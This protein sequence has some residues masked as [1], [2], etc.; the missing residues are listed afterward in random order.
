MT[1]QL[2][3]SDVERIAALDATE[4]AALV[5][6]G[7]LT[8]ADLVS[9]AITRIEQANPA[10]NAV[11]TT[12]FEQAL[13]FVAD[14]APSGP[15]GGVPFLL[16]DLVAE[17]AGMRYAAGSEFLRDH[18]STV[19]SELVVRL[20]RAG[21]V[22][23]G[24]TNTCEFGMVPTTEPLRF[25]ATRNPWDLNRT[26]GGSS[27]GSAAAVASGMVPMAHAN[28]AGGSIRIPASCCGLFGLKPTRGRN[29]LGPLYGDAYGGL[30]VEHA[31]TRSVRDSAALLD[32]T[33]G[34]AP[35]DPCAAVGPVGGLSAGG[36]AAEVSQPPGRLRVAVTTATPE[37]RPVPGECAAAAQDAAALCEEL[38]HEVVERDMTELTPE[39]GK[40]IGTVFSAATA[41]S[42]DVWAHRLGRTP[43]DGELEPFTRLLYDHGRKITAPDYL[44]AVTT[45][46]L[47]G[48][49]VAEA[50]ES[51]DVW[52]SPTLAQPPLPLG[53]MVG[54]P[55]APYAGN[56]A[57]AGFSAFPLVAANIT[58][59][60][61]MS[62]PLHWTASGLPVGVHVTAAVGCEATLFRLA[63]QL[64]EARPWAGRRP[65]VWTGV[66]P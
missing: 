25:G 18:R 28:D 53:V 26:I 57:A 8:A 45:L 39:V 7:E 62:V 10:L 1:T 16:K 60:P 46:Q 43:Q 20:R 35:G 50:F 3:A 65:A 11:I 31:V 61:A 54:T 55:D 13:G 51:F 27:G 59:G 64:E 14:G 33:A 17:A 6:S 52:L 24:K 63:G 9:S 19:D 42:V 58:G 44:L 56:D 4:Q 37:G 38:G 36:F 5:R 2:S 30:G 15:L 12:A 32:A 21:L 66:R 22:V 41:W 49:G 47:F 29:P 23:L 34:P 40:A 48:R